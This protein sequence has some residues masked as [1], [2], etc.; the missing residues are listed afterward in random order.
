MLRDL[1]PFEKA[2]AGAKAAS[3]EAL[4]N[5]LLDL[6]TQFKQGKITERTYNCAEANI[7]TDMK[8]LSNSYEAMTGE[9]LSL[10]ATV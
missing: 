1:S 5:Y 10:F 4:E 2:L 9:P 6:G 7:S 8:A 3:F